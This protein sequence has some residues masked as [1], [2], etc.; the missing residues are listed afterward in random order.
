VVKQVCRI[1]P[2]VGRNN[3]RAIAIFIDFRIGKSSFK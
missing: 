1:F 3:G 2:T